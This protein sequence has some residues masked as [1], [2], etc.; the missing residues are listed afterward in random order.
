MIPTIQNAFDQ[1]ME[2]FAKHCLRY[3]TIVQDDSGE[4]VKGHWRRYVIAIQGEQAFIVKEN[5]V[6]TGAMIYPR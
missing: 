3:G 1:G 6:T 2:V 5:G 4:Y